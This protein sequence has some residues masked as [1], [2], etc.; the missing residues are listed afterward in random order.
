MSCE[1]PEP[2]FQELG[3]ET[4]EPA[5]TEIESLCMNCHANGTTRLLLARIPYYKNVVV[6]S[7]SCEECGY[8]NNEL[9]S[10]GAYADKGVTWI[11]RVE[12]AE[13]LNRQVVKS[14]YTA[15]KI[16]EL[17]FEIPAQSQKGEVTTIEGIVSR[18]VR[19]LSQDQA[20]RRLQHP[21][22]AAQI[23]EFVDRLGALQTG[24]KPWTIELTDIT[25]NCFLENPCAPRRDPRARRLSFERSAE[26]NR[27]LGIYDT[28]HT[29]ENGASEECPRVNGAARTGE[30]HLLGP[31]EPGAMPYERLAADEVLS[32]RTNC[33]D[34]GAPCDTNMKMTNIPHFKEVVIMST[35]C[36]VCGHRTN[37]VKSGGGIEDKGVRFELR[38]ASK[39]DFSRDV[40]K[41]ETCSMEIPEL[42]L[43]VGGRALGG[44][45]T[46]AEGL[47][48]ATAAQLRD[49]PGAIGDAPGVNR[50]RLDRFVEKVEEVLRGERA[51]T[52][53]LDDPAGNSYVQSLA[54][55]P[56][57]PDDGLKVTRYTRSF[58]QDEELGINDMR[59]ED[60]VS[61]SVPAS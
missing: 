47:I 3:E 12:G 1:R 2:V 28:S 9:Q 30:G 57:L 23:Q 40:L 32:F 20:A 7:F 52:V 11:L 22:E 18:A 8:Q 58:E 56:S 46:T 59:T 15:V 53:I 5:V 21:H 14:D 48:S 4:D 33:P 31:L 19:G 39:E 44:R 24:N 35:T 42:E 36:D 10:A 37:E 34:C 50:E 29:E 54:P 17:D 51:V 43:E 45:F 55:D 13:D 41:S 60:Y 27:T 6:M 16:P 25:G 26:Q 38:I 61:P 49:S